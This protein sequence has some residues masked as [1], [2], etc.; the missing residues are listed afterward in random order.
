MLARVTYA[1]VGLALATLIGGF[2]TPDSN[3]L[4]FISIGLSVG[5]ILLVLVGAA[6][7]AREAPGVVLDEE[8]FADVDAD[9]EVDEALAAIGEED[10]EDFEELLDVDEEEDEDVFADEDEEEEEPEPAPRRSAARTKTKPK[11]KPKTKPKPKATKSKPKTKTKTTS[12]AAR[13]IVVPGRDRYHSSGCR[14]VKGKSGD[15]IERITE[16]TAKR[17]GFEPCSVCSPD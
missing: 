5:A 1:L 2:F 17:R 10:E 8:L 14:F 9:E 4:L 6:R 15:E 7:R 11:A 13:V 3:V 16:A 12:R